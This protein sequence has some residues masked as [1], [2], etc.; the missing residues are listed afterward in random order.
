MRRWLS[1]SNKNWKKK[2]LSASGVEQGLRDQQECLRQI[3]D[4][5]PNM[6]YVKNGEG[7]FVLVN[8][9]FADYYGTPIENI[10]GKSDAEFNSNKEEVVRSIQQDKEVIETLHRKV[11]EEQFTN[12][13]THKTHWF[14][15][16]RLPLL[17]SDSKAH[18]VLG[19]CTDI[20][21]HRQRREPS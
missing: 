6:I 4:L 13:I 3:I 14:E 18:Q 7:K 5:N 21:E 8:K 12:P 10:V 15:T 9:A 1:W 19:V 20:T 17:S 2:L 16:I 11:T